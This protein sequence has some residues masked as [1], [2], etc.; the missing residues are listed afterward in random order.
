MITQCNGLSFLKSA[1]IKDI[2]EYRGSITISLH[3][4]TSNNLQKG[5]EWAGSFEINAPMER[6]NFNKEGW[7]DDIPMPLLFT[8]EKRQ[9]KWLARGLQKASCEEVQVL[10]RLQKISPM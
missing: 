1:H 7:T 8:V 10:N 6:I 3:E 9:G 5:I 4:P 2:R